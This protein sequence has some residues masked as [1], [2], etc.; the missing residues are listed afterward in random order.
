MRARRLLEGLTPARRALLPP[1]FLQSIQIQASGRIE[2]PVEDAVTEPKLAAINLEDSFEARPSAPEWIPGEISID[3]DDSLIRDGEPSLLEPDPEWD[4]VDDVHGTASLSIDSYDEVDAF[5]EGPTFDEPTS[6]D[7]PTNAPAHRQ[8]PPPGESDDPIADG[9]IDDRTS[10]PGL[11]ALDLHTGP[12]WGSP[13]PNGA[14]GMGDVLSRGRGPFGPR[15]AALRL[16][17]LPDPEYKQRSAQLKHR[18]KAILDIDLYTGVLFLHRR[19]PTHLA[20][21]GELDALRGKASD[22]REAGLRVLLVD[23]DT[24]LED[25]LPQPLESIE[26]ARPDPIQARTEAGFALTIDRTGLEAAVFGEV[27][28]DE[29]TGRGGFWMLDLLIWRERAPLRIRSDR[30]NLDF[31]GDEN[32]AAPRTVARNLVRWLSADPRHP[33]PLDEN[34]RHVPA[35]ARSVRSPTV[36]VHPIEGDFTE[37]VLLYDLGR[38]G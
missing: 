33:V 27:P 1:D 4:T 31:L 25:A 2:E 35:S 22:L 28:A 36:D 21:G 12:D 32:F 10:A 18:L 34:F 17:L 29:D 3:L 19:I 37:Y 5:E 13:P 7:G 14:A 15:D 23:A 20:A 8:A 24:W 30:V 16:L 6:F 26:G 11:A 9:S 38:R